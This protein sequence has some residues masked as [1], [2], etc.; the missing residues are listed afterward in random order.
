MFGF[1]KKR[2]DTVHKKID[3]LHNSVSFSFS[4]I[5]RD[6]DYV[7]NWITHFKEKHDK[8]DNNFEKVH[9][10]LERIE[11]EL[12]E[13]RELWTRVQ[14]GVQTRVQTA[15]QTGQTRV[16]TRVGQT[17]VR[18]KQMSVQ[19]NT[20]EK[21][22]NLSGMERGLVWVLLNTDTK[23]SYDELYVV[24]GKNK[25]TLRGQINNIKLKSPE[26]I[27]ELVEND[28]TKRFYV[29][30]KVKEEILG[31]GQKIEVRAKKK[32]KRSK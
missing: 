6:M 25:S 1:F 12:E 18:L 31:K 17:D 7:G 13:M 20:L 11:R 28:G 2:D 14:T 29:D 8:H 9:N 27:K 21:L 26:L 22:K 15:V 30:E 10:R 4:N 19:A 23:M 16:Q 3:D 5:K 24:L 32:G